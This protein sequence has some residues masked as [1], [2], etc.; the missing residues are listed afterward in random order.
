MIPTREIQHGEHDRMSWRHVAS[1]LP[2][3]DESVTHTFS[4][5]EYS[6]K[7]R[8]MNINPFRSSIYEASLWI[9]EMLIITS[10]ALKQKCGL[11]QNVIY[12]ILV[13]PIQKE[14]DD[15]SVP[16][17]GTITMVPH[18][19]HVIAPIAWFSFPSHRTKPESDQS[20]TAK[21][22]TFLEAS[23]WVLRKQQPSGSY[24]NPHL[25]L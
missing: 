21:N 19:N 9:R 24:S 11:V 15:T 16:W 14:R 17:G 10:V 6:S 20:R 1:R 22:T 12:G 13:L 8:Y 5:Q 23:C 7:I 2:E 4:S 25:F 3:V 18:G